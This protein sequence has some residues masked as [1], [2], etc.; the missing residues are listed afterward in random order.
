MQLR[1]NTEA[2]IVTVTGG[3][4]ATSSSL[5]MVKGFTARFRFPSE[6]NSRVTIGY[7]E[8][9]SI[10]LARNADVNPFFCGNDGFT[11]ASVCSASA[12]IKIGSVT[13]DG[14]NP[15]N[16]NMEIK[17]VGGGGRAL[18]N[19]NIESGCPATTVGTNLTVNCADNEG[20]M[21]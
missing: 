5:Q 15:H 19:C 8:G 21:P 13:I 20:F 9:G 6:Q 14:G 4:T 12:P 10:R 16:Y 2:D 18:L 11:T 17:L 3:P 1:T 7:E